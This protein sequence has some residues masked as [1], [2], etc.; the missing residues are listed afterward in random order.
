MLQNQIVPVVSVVNQKPTTNSLNVA[1][2]FG[3][4]HKNVL[5]VIG[6]LEIPGETHRLFFQPISYKDSY[7]RDQDAYNLTRDGFTLLVM[8]FTG[9]KAMRFKIAYIEAFNRMEEEL[10]RRE[11]PRKALPM[12][13]EMMALP[14]LLP[15][16]MIPFRVNLV[17]PKARPTWM[18]CA[19]CGGHRS[20]WAF[21]KT[22]E[23]PHGGFCIRCRRKV[24]AGTMNPEIEAGAMAVW[25]FQE[26]RP[27][28]V[29][30]LRQMAGNA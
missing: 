21:G 11:Y 15:R 9:A 19:A 5:Q 8:G 10:R 18:V 26:M 29:K 14:D 13:A 12:P 27:I 3:K 7:G 28:A 4:A 25:M 17:N 16:Q 1:A 24:R 20:K 23:A 2:V 22:P 30:M 6:T